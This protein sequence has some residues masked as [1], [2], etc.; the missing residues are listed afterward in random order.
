LHGLGSDRRYWDRVA[1]ELRPLPVVALDARGHGETPEPAGATD[2]TARQRDESSLSGLAADV[3]VALDALGLSRVLAVGHSWGGAIA[4]T[5][6]AEHPERVLGVIA[7]DGGFAVRRTSQEQEALAAELL[8]EDA[9]PLRRAQL[10]ALLDLE[11]GEVLS[12][13]SVPC[14][15]VACSPVPDPSSDAIPGARTEAR[16]HE[17]RSVA[18][19]EASDDRTR[20][21]LA[22]LDRAG[23][24]LARPRLM[25]WVG[26]DHDVPLRWPALVT[27]LIRAAADDVAGG[28][29]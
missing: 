23:Q 27:G 15:L 9:S 10:A 20:R 18:I 11:P 7:L 8:P 6:A 4:L 1:P 5:L 2:A 19:G 22:G 26:V 12:R 21:K 28:G 29:R 13:I 16:D 3:A 14:W 25:H 24:L 17:Q